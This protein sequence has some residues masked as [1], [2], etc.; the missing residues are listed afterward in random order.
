MHKETLPRYANEVLAWEYDQR[1]PRPSPG[2]LE[3]YI[4]YAHQSG[5]PILE[6]A[7]GSGRLLI[8]I[9]QAGHRIDGVDNSEAMLDRLKNK[10][11]VTDAATARRIRVFCQDML[12]FRSDRQYAMVIVAYNSLQYLETKDRIH[13]CFGRIFNCLN[14]DG[15]F[16]FTVRRIDLSSFTEGKKVVLDWMEKPVVDEDSGL[17]VGAKFV[18][19]LDSDKNR[20]IN[21]RTYKVTSPDGRSKII[22]SITYTPLIEIPDYVRMLEGVGFTVKVSNGYDEQLEDEVSKEICYV[23]K[24]TNRSTS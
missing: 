2:E 3:W 6:L 15:Y 11:K 21:G 24:K 4:R 7:C 23:C 9:A 16:L 12:E 22:N 8:P 1:Q 19:Y 14:Q 13:D 10:L 18:P 20:I 17:K 5:D